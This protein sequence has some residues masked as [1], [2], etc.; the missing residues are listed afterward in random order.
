MPGA[1]TMRITGTRNIEVKLI[2][3]GPRVYNR[4]LAGAVQASTKPMI[5]A[6]RAMVPVD[7]GALKKSIGAVRR[8]NKMRQ[9]V[10]DVVG[11]RSGFET[12]NARGKKHIPSKIA[13]LVEKQTPF[14]RP[15]FDEH[16]DAARAAATAKLKQAVEREARRK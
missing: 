13:H 11:S 5:R 15:A 14:L 8:R 12:V 4:A 9:T 3:L 6:A 16:K 7:T 2:S 10:Y 1:M